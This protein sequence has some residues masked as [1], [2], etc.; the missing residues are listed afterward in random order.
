M[1]LGDSFGSSL[2]SIW[3]HKL[4]SLLTLTGIMIGVAAVVTMFSSISGIKLMI[5][6]RM[7]GM[8]WDRSIVIYP[9]SGEN[10]NQ[11]RKSRFMYIQRRPRPLSYDD[12]LL[13]KKEVDCGTIYGRIDQWQQFQVGE[14]RKWV[15][16]TA[17]SNDYFRNKTYPLLMGRYF[18]S[19]E[20]K[21]KS[22]VCVIGYHFY[23]RNF[24]NEDPL[25][26][27]ITVGGNRYQIIGVLDEDILNKGGMN[28][29][30]PWDRRWDLRAVYIPLS[31]GSQLL[32][33]D[34]ALDNI[35]MQARKDQDYDLMKTRVF[36]TLL[37]SHSMAHD[38]EFNDVGSFMTKITEEISKF[39]RTWN[40]TLSAIASI[41]LLVGG[42]GLFSTLLIS[43]NEKMLEIGIRKSVGAREID[44]FLYFII[45]ALTLA[46]LSAGI[47]I[48][49]SMILIQQVGKPM[50]FK[51]PMP[52]EG[53]LLGLGFA[54]F[55][56]LISGLYP[57]IKAA[58]VDPVRAIFYFE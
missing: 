30:N 6:K 44:I 46:V 23:N 53:I 21:N 36:Q 40:I 52:I 37:A 27:T 56:G 55:I 15:R 45:E 24:A 41:S 11:R 26:Q 9:S 47:G 50:G 54:I 8:G 10:Q 22:R 38:F 58:R 20:N 39:M 48:S 43:I 42:I 2:S 17:V 57:A 32:R 29:M 25:N 28:Q 34:Y 14:K 35:Y 33:K 1:H 16:L 4:R 7:E 18:S 49:F 12:Y 51:L 19:F 5:M 31:T 13:L 3:S